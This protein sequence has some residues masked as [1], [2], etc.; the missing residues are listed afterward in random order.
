MQ[1]FNKLFVFISDKRENL[2]CCQQEDRNENKNTLPLTIW[3]LI[4]LFVVGKNVSF[5]SIFGLKYSFI[6]QIWNLCFITH[7]V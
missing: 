2:F 3:S 6:L 4:I 5:A 1:F 7:L